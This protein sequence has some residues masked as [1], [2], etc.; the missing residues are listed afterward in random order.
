VPA[1][2]ARSTDIS[3]AVKGFTGRIHWIRFDTGDDSHDHLI[4]PDH[5][6]RVAM[7]RQ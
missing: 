3:P 1:Y 5:L 7:I 2:C 6:L 4:D